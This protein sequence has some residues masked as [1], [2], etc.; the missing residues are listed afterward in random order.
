[1]PLCWGGLGIPNLAAAGLEQD[2]RRID[3]RRKEEGL[4]KEG[5]GRKD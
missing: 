2:G 5:K 3:M 4:W 1:M